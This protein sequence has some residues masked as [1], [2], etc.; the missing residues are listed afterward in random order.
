MA[1]S[2]IAQGFGR[3]LASVFASV[4]AIAVFAGHAPARADEIRTFPAKGSYEDVKTDL[5]NAVINRGLVSDYTGNIGRMLER[6]GADV[7]STKPVYKSA[8]YLTFCSA[9]FSRLMMEADPVNI[10]FCPFV[11]FVYELA[12]RPANAAGSVVI[13]YRRPSSASGNAATK[14]VLADIDKLLSDI[15]TE[16]TK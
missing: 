9:K 12:D 6:T 2:K 13:G 1:R 11:M 5:V 10:G 14:A 4:L 3:V 7:G 8:D 15:A 16:A